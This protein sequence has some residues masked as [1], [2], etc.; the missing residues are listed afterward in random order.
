[1]QREIYALNV[2]FGIGA[3][4]CGMLGLVSLIIA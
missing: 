3:A 4:A 2:L 1:M